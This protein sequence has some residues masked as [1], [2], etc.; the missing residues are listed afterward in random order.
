[1]DGPCWEYVEDQREE[2]EKHFHSPDKMNKVIILLI[3]CLLLIYC[4][5]CL[6]LNSSFFPPNSFFQG[7]RKNPDF[8]LGEQ[9]DRVLS[10]L[11]FLSSSPP[12]PFL[13]LTVSFFRP[14]EPVPS[15]LLALLPPSTWEALLQVTFSPPSFGYF[16]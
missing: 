6:F 16:Q 3:N 10:K 7:K 11:K 5:I 15:D 2:A 13:S 12:F 8:K 9:L 14:G 1:M 4:F